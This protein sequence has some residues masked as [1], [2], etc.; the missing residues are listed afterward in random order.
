M[1]SG[2]MYESSLLLL[3]VFLVKGEWLVERCSLVNLNWR[4][5]WHTNS[6]SSELRRHG[7][8]YAEA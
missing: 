2:P 1:S 7:L 3:Y 4:R 6:H 8:L 5:S